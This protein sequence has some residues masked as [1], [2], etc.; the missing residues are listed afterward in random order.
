[1]TLDHPPV[2]PRSPGLGG[3]HRPK[4]SGAEP[5]LSSDARG[6]IHNAL[7]HL[8]ASRN[9]RAAV[10]LAADLGDLL[11]PRLLDGL[12]HDAD[13]VYRGRCALTLGLLH[14]DDALSPLMAA[15]RADS[16]ARVRIA[17]IEALAAYP[18]P[19][20][21]EYVIPLVEALSDRQIEVRRRVVLALGHSGDPRAVPAMF[22][23]LADDK[24]YVRGAAATALSKVHGVNILEQ[25]VDLLDHP[26][27]I[28]R[29]H[30]AQA[31]TRFNNET[32]VAALAR[33][34]D[35][36]FRPQ[37]HQPSTADFAADALRAI[38]T[39]SALRY[40]STD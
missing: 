25:M 12:A 28:L 6:R 1:M 9:E 39:P 36:V 2:D 18:P 24:G 35:D 40:L 15:L 27:S 26:A 5:A 3:P 4:L 31:L 11:T 14:P 7:R 38:G 20:L 13:P 21:R 30:A 8:R 33:S 29:W 32:A 34:L 19:A 16:A 37:P 23:L 17:A 10:Q 22:N